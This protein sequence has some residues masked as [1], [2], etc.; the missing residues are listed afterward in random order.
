MS[1]RF[2]FILSYFGNKLVRSLRF[3]LVKINALRVFGTALGGSLRTV[4]HAIRRFAVPPNRIRSRTCFPTWNARSRAEVAKLGDCAKKLLF[5]EDMSDVQFAVGRDYGAVK[6]FP[7][8]KLLMGLRSAVFHVMFYGSLP[9]KCSAPID[10]PDAHPDAFA[11]MLSYIYTDMVTNLTHDNVFDTLKCA[12]KYDLPLL[13]AMC[14]NVVLDTLNL[15]NCLQILDNAVLY[16][17]P[18]PKILEKCLALIDQ[19]PLT[20]WQSDQFCEIGQE[21]LQAILKRDTLTANEDTICSAVG[22]WATKMCTL[23]N[24]DATFANRREALGQAFFLIR[25]PLLTDAQL[26]DEPVKSGLLLLSEVLDISLCK[27]GTIKPQLPFCAEPRRNVLA[28]G[29]INFTIP[30][31]RELQTKPAYSSPVTIRKLLWRI[32]IVKETVGSSAALGFFLYCSGFPKSTSWTCK[33]NA[34]LRLLPWV[35]AIAPIE[36]K[37]SQLFDENSCSWGCSEYI[38]M[39]DLLDPSNGYVD[40]GD[41]SL[42]LQV[43]VNADLPVGIE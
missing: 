25:F 24:M 32:V 39:E 30:D 5:C 36:H 7:A 18:A 1:F 34:E 40:P 41:F 43:Y 14:T 13:V 6:I 11:N 16:A 8:H 10:I 31:V 9:D 21:A 2:T 35:A 15:N 28:E 19:S 20:I 22:R 26:L 3:W 27:Q 17:G 29:V 38:S 33:V 4:F 42:K 12:D 37:M 23:R